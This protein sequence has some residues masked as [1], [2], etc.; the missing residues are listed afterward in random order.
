G[1][2][3]DHC[4]RVPQPRNQDGVAL[5]HVV[6]VLRI[7]ASGA[8][9]SSL[10]DV[11]DRDRQSVQRTPALTSRRRLVRGSSPLPRPVRIQRDNSVESR[12]KALDPFQIAVEQLTAG[13]LLRLQQLQ[14]VS[15]RQK[16]NVIYA[17]GP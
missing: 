12:V 1:L 11:L 6:A 10:E 5:R 8:Q 4:P 3:E 14:Q 15:R 9:P 16:S 13:D 7:T 17:H 2:P